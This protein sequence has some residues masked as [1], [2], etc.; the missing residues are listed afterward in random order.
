MPPAI[1]GHLLRQGINLMKTPLYEEHR[2]LGA[3]MT[4]FAG[5]E[6]PLYYSGVIREVTAVRTSAGI[7]D[8]SHMGEIFVS[9]PHA[10]EF[11]Q[12]LTTN[13]LS[14][15]QVG[16]AQYTLLCSETGG[17]I[18]DLVIY[19]L[20]PDEY[21][22]VVNA[23]NTETDLQWINQRNRY[24]AEVHDRSLETGLIAVQGPKSQDLFQPLISSDLSK[25]PRFGVEEGVVGDIRCLIARTGYTGEDGF[26]LYCRASD[27][28]ALWRLLMDSSEQYEALSAGLAARDVLRLEAGYPLYGNELTL[29]T[30]PV[31]AGLMW[32]VKLDKGDFIGKEAIQEAMKRGPR[33]KLVGLEALDR[34]VPRHDYEIQAN[35]INIGRITSGTF[36]PALGKGIAMA[37]VDPKFAV[38]GTMVEMPLRGKECKLR[39]RSTRFYST[40]KNTAKTSQPGGSDVS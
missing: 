34:C 24:D 1:P 30:T 3:K 9:G 29:D 38:E 13:D 35:G 23:S 39:M 33:R 18:D 8:L 21:M 26:E 5:W 10:L 12:V 6:M 15:L 31:D 19:R 4:E 40:V 7:F 22:L 36:S 2:R 32:V 27:C 17:I 37:Y 25:L 11:L 16:K 28:V 20:S 14:K